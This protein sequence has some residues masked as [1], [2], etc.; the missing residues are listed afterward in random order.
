MSPAQQTTRY[1]D[2]MTTN[3]PPPKTAREWVGRNIR[4]ERERRGLKVEQL[5][6]LLT[7]RGFVIDK[8]QVSRIENGRQNCDVEKLL[9][10]ADALEVNPDRLLRDPE[11]LDAALFARIVRHWRSAEREAKRYSTIAGLLFEEL[12]LLADRVPP[13][14]T[15]GWTAAESLADDTWGADLVRWVP[16]VARVAPEHPDYGAYIERLAA[17]D[18]A[19]DYSELDAELEGNPLPV[20]V[21][22][23]T[24]KS[25]SKTTKKGGK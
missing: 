16:N 5:A 8:S 15:T 7:E 17:G 6:R 24:T 19:V 1:V 22:G 12:L 11:R 2:R 4:R 18:L 10:F 14:P 3:S 25:K 21:P 9:A 13:D 20:F 23:T